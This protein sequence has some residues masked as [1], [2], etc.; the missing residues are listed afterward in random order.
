MLLLD[1]FISSFSD[2]REDGRGNR[3]QENK[4]E[5]GESDHLFFPLERGG[6]MELVLSTVSGG[7]F[8]LLISL[9]TGTTNHEKNHEN[10][11]TCH[12]CFFLGGGEFLL[13]TLKA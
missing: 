6:L 7:L 2:G 11:A 12:F 10:D 3:N 9:W 13:P 8:D 4:G 5:N 1:L